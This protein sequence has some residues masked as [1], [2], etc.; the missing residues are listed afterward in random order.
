MHRFVIVLTIVV[1]LSNL[2]ALGAPSMSAAQDTTPASPAEALPDTPVGEALAWVLTLLNDGAASLTSDE[3]TARFAPAFLAAVPPE[4]IV[5]LPRQ[6]S[7]DAPYAFH[8][9]TRPPTA[10]QGNALLSG[11]SGTPLVVPL[12]VEAAPPHRITGTNFVPVPPPPGVSLPTIPSGEAPLAAGELRTSDTGRLDAL[13]EVDG[14]QIYL[15]CVGTGSPTVVL[16]SGLNDA[17]APWFAIEHAV[18]PDTRVCSYDR[19]N[20]IGSASDPT[21]TPRTLQDLVDDLHTV[22]AVAEVPGPY[23]LV[24]HS[25]GGLIVRLYAS[26]YPEEVAGLVLVDASHEE[27]VARFEALVSPELWAA[28][29]AMT[30]QVLNAEGL[31]LD[32]SFTQMR[33]AR[34]TAPLHPMPLVVISASAAQDP[35]QLTPFFPPRVA[36]RAYATGAPGA[37][38][39]SRGAGAEW[40][41]RHRGAERALRPSVPA[42]AGRRGHSPS[43]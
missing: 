22:L 40:A 6:F 30:G 17:A 1:A 21:P 35:A 38:S 39:R 20:T 19:A 13:V 14:R 2:R 8:G 27:Q 33:Q 4:L 7:A 3:I 12:A 32:A 43:G 41:A 16:E 9:F 29:Q 23:V 36:G 34:T 28:Y 10:T 26:T 31:D 5:G 11:R 37:A 25:I 18:A 15:S 24:G 42:R